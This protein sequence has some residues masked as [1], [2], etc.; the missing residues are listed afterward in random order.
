MQENSLLE[1]KNLIYEIRNQR[2]MLDSDLA[3]LYGVET[4]NLNRAVKRNIERFPEDFMF[5]LTEEEWQVLRCQFGTSN[6]RGGRKYLPYAFNEH[7]ILMLSNVLHSDLAI[8]TSIQI[9]RV[10]EQLRKYALEQ[11][12][13]TKEI[14]DLRKM[15]MLHIEN[16]DNK[17]KQTDRTI[18]NIINVL[19]NLVE[20][21]RKTKPIG[22][23]TDK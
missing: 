22:F 23:N 11:T 8:K 20:T 19:N 16:T 3:K 9:I 18:Q 7:G 13:K 1:V 12:E 6:K 15:L 14:E 21:P 17:M 10:F 4:K 5:Q 2:V